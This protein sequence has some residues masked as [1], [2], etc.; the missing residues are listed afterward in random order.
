MV[1]RARR[2]ERKA[3]WTRAEFIILSHLG[4]CAGDSIR[5]SAA[6][7]AEGGQSTRLFSDAGYGQIRDTQ[8]EAGVADRFPHN[9]A[10]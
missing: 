3:I 10:P 4:N 7:E 2:V 1:P 8:N 6:G 9:A 5:L